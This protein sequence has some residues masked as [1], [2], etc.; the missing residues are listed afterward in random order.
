LAGC[1]M[2]KPK[3]CPRPMPPPHTHPTNPTPPHSTPSCSYGAE[4]GQGAVRE[5]V[6]KTF[7]PNMRSVGPRWGVLVVCVCLWGVYGR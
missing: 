4:Q 1:T 5:A 2:T 7:Y 6:A 3:A